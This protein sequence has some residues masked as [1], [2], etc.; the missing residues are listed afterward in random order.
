[1]PGGAAVPADAISNVTVS[2]THRRRGLLSRMMAGDLADAKARGDVV[3]TLIAAE[4]PIYGRFGFG[5]ATALSEWAVDVPRAGLDPRRPVPDDGGRIDLVDGEDVRKT[6]PEL[7]ERLRASRPASSIA[8]GSGGVATPDS[9]KL[10]KSPGKSPSTRS[11]A[12]RTARP[13][14]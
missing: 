2:A 10:R 1:M 9:S 8:T 6:G 4:Y 5:P 14:A 11:T 13:R 3:A 12:L 7:H